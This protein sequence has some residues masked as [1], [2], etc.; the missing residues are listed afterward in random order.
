MTVA[1]TSNFFEQLDRLDNL[2]DSDDQDE[3]S[4]SPISPRDDSVVYVVTL[5]AIDFQLRRHAQEA[6]NSCIWLAKKSFLAHNDD[7]VIRGAGTEY[8]TAEAVAQAE[9]GHVGGRG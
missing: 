5:L 8:Q 9:R 3:M 7:D 2:S 6:I 4:I 1:T